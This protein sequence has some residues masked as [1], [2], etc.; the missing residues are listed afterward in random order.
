[1]EDISKLDLFAIA[2]VI[3]CWGL[4]GAFFVLTV[5]VVVG[6][7]WAVFVPLVINYAAVK[8][9]ERVQKKQLMEL[10]ERGSPQRPKD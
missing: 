6:A 4:S 2:L 8:E 3:A 7:L 10:S 5:N 9:E 1:M